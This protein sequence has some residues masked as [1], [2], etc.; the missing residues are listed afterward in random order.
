STK[1]TFASEWPAMYATCVGEFVAYT[2]TVTPPADIVPRSATCQSGRFADRMQ[3]A[4]PGSTPREARPIA[5]SRTRRP[6]SC[7]AMV[8]H[9]P[10]SWKCM[11][12]R[13]PIASTW[14]WKR[15]VIVSPA[16]VPPDSGGRG[17]S[18]ACLSCRFSQPGSEPG[19]DDRPGVGALH[20]RAPGLAHPSGALRVVEETG[21]HL[22][23][24]T[25]V[26]A[27][28]HEPRLAVDDGLRRTPGGA[29]DAGPSA[30]GRLEEHV[31]PSLDLEAEEAVPA[32]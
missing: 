25:G 4:S 7:Q 27:V 11:A 21:H 9:S 32:R 5:T 8:R 14:S 17:S 24:L 10:S 15:F 30:R 1:M 29:R 3:T 2:G 23:D 19:G 13:S 26:P 6:Y 31:A 20:P 22:G 16:I 18:P 28:H 12:G